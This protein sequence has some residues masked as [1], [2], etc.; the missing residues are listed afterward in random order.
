MVKYYRE[1]I[2][3]CSQIP[4]PLTNSL[5]SQRKKNSTVIVNS[6]KLVAFKN[7]KETL[8]NYTK[9]SYIGRGK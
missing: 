3:N 8:I 1:F 2:P 7:A 9:L 4:M 6:N 5:Q